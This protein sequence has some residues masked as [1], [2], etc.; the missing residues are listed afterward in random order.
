MTLS[1]EDSISSCCSIHEKQ[2]VGD[3]VI[4]VGA[5]TVSSLNALQS[6]IRK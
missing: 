6:G 3:H 5:N 2:T 1:F 4:R